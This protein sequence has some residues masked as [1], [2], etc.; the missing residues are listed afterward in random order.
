LVPVLSRVKQAAALA[1][2]SVRKAVAEAPALH[3]E[4]VPAV[5][6]AVAGYAFSLT[7]GQQAAA[8]TL[9]VVAGGVAS[10]LV[11]KPPHVAV[12]AAMVTSASASLAVLGLHLP[13]AATA[14]VLAA[15][16]LVPLVRTP[17]KAPV[18]QQDAP[19]VP[20]SEYATGL[21]ASSVPS[22]AAVVPHSAGP[23]V[24]PGRPLWTSRPG[25]GRRP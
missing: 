12:T 6:L 11:R 20:K 9:A 5:A 10:G 15:A 8:W 1:T 13:H 22:S 23:M 18:A 17:P 2:A 16:S 3:L 24:P 21:V 14:A 7:P 19:V 25:Q 4:S